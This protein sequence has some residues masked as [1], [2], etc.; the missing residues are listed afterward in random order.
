MQNQNTDP[1]KKLS[2][3]DFAAKI[4]TKYPQYADI[5]DGQL[6]DKITAKYPQYKE[7]IDFSVKKKEP[8]KTTATA[9]KPVSGLETTTQEPAKKDGSLATT[10]P[11]EIQQNE[12]LQTLLSEYD[13]AKQL[14]PED[15]Q[16]IAQTVEQESTMNFG[17]FDRMKQ[18]YSVASQANPF[19]PT[20]NYQDPNAKLRRKSA[21]AIA[22]DQEIDVNEVS[23]EQVNERVMQERTRELAQQKI[24]NKTEEFIESRSAETQQILNEHFNIKSEKLTNQSKRI[25]LEN[26]DAYKQVEVLDAQLESIKANHSKDQEYTEEYYANN[27]KLVAQRNALVDQIIKRNETLNETNEDLLSTQNEIDLFKRNYGKVYNM[28]SKFGNA[29]EEMSANLIEFGYRFST[30]PLLDNV[31]PEGTETSIAFDAMMKNIREGIAAEKE[32]LRRPRDLSNLQSAEDFTEWAMDLVAEQ[33]PNTIVMAS[34]GGSSSLAVLGASA[35][36]AKFNEMTEEEKNSLGAVNYTEAQKYLSA[37]GAFVFEAG[38]ERISLG[39]IRQAKR[40]FQTIGRDQLKESASKYLKR[41]VPE[42][43]QRVTEE[44]GTEAIAQFSQNLADKYYLGKDIDLMQGVGESFISGAFMSGVIYQAP[45]IFSGI[46]KSFSTKDNNQKIGENLAKIKQFNEQLNSELSPEVATKIAAKRDAL[47]LQNKNILDKS[48]ADIDELTY[49]QKQEILD[50]ENQKY[51]LRQETQRLNEESNLS[52]DVRKQLIE[53]NAAKIEKLDEQRQGI[54]LEREQNFLSVLPAEEQ[55]A[56]K[57]QAQRELMAEYEAQGVEEYEI[58]DQ[59]IT[60]RAVSLFE[61]QNTETNA[62]TQETT[63]EET[64]PEVL[65]AQDQKS[66]KIKV[67]HGTSGDFDRF[68]FNSESKGFGQQDLGKGVYFTES[69]ERADGYRKNA[70]INNNLPAESGRVMEVSITVNNPIDIASEEYGNLEETYSDKGELSQAIQDAGYDGIVYTVNGKKNYVVFNENQI[71]YSNES[72]PAQDPAI[73]EDVRPEPSQDNNTTENQDVQPTVESE[74]STTEAQTTTKRV[75]PKGVKGE[76]DVELDT[77]GEVTRVISVK[78]GREI[79]KFTERTNKRTGKKTMVRNANYSRIANEAIGQKTENQLREEAKAKTNVAID[80]YTPTNAYEAALDYFARGGNIS[81]A[82]ATK[83]TGYTQVEVKWAAGFNKDTDL[84]S[85]ERAAE[86]IVAESDLDL[87]VNEV[88]NE[89][90]AILQ[91]KQ[92]V[93]EVQN[94]IVALQEEANARQNEE[95]LYQYLGT[96]SEAQLTAYE[97]QVAEDTYLEQLTYEEQIEYYEGQYGTQDQ[98]IEAEIEG[99]RQTKPESESSPASIQERS[100]PQ[101]EEESGQSDDAFLKWLNKQSQDLDDFSKGTLGINL[102]VAVAQGAIKIVRTAYTAG[103]SASQAI[104]EALD[105]IKATDWYKGLSKK[106][107]REV[108][109]DLVKRAVVQENMSD[110]QTFDYIEKEFEEADK[111]LENKQPA[112]KK[113]QSLIRKFI[114]K[115]SDRQFI[116]KKLVDEVGAQQTKDAMINSHGASGKA[117]RIFD[118][119]FYQIYSDNL[120]YNQQGLQGYKYTWKPMSNADRAML[121]KIIQL[122]RFIAID[123]NRTEKGLPPVT[124]PGFIN[125]KM[126]QKY[127][128]HVKVKLGDEKFADIEKRAAIYFKTY[129]TLLEEMRKNGLIS[130]AVFES[131]DGLDYQP[132]LFLQHITDFEGNVSLGAAQ[133]EKSDTGGLSQDQIKAL[134]E[135]SSGVLVRNSEWLLATSIVARQRAMAMNTVNKVFMTKEFPAAKKRYQE[136]K[137]D[138]KNRKKWSREDERFYTYFTELNSK[139]KDNPI[140]KQKK[141]TEQEVID[142]MEP[143]YIYTRK[144]DK[145]PANFKKAYYYENGVRHEFFIEENLHDAWFDNIPGFLN[146]KAKEFLGYAMGASLLKGIATGNNPAFALV[147]TPRDYIFNVVFSDQ[148]SSIVPKAMYQVA[149]DTFKAIREIKRSN[150]SFGADGS[151]LDK[152]IYYGG[153]MAFLSTQGRLKQNTRLAKTIDK[154]LTPRVKNI[155]GTIFKAVTLRKLSEY[156]EVMFRMALFQRTIKNEL[157]ARGLKSMNA[158]KTQAEKDQIYM[159]AVA[160]ARSLLDFN[161]G[162]SYTKDAEAFIPYINTAVQ[163]TRVAADAFQKNPDK[164]FFKVMQSAVMLSGA[165]VLGSLALIKANKDDEEEKSAYE[166]WLE[167]ME[168]VSQYQRIQYFNIVDGT[169]DENGEYRVW[170]IAKNQQLAPVLN[171]ADNVYTQWVSDI[172]GVKRKDSN[173]NYAEAWTAIQNN[174]IPF[175]LEKPI[176]GNLTKTPVIKAGFTYGTGHDFYRDQPLTFD[177]N[178]DNPVMEGAQDKNVDDFYKEIGRE[179]RLSPARLKGAVE[180]LITTPRTNPFIGVLYAGADGIASEDKTLKDMAGKVGKDMLSSFDKRVISHTSD[181]NRQINRLRPVED[182]LK[183]IKTVNDYR[184]V[185]LE[186]L[187]KD[188]YNNK[189]SIPVFLEKLQEMKPTEKEAKKIE[190]K[191]KSLF[192]YKDVDRYVIGLAFESDREARA[193]KI[194]RYYGNVFDGSPENDRVFS[195]M[196]DMNVLDPETIVEYQKLVNKMNQ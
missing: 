161:Q 134:G 46:A 100:R 62:E 183:E 23:P 108:N 55:Q 111:A 64:Q 17:F 60:A 120:Y 36:G 107:Q 94:E 72:T 106:E 171:I 117:K 180:S 164:I 196:V 93:S 190:S 67:Y 129:H 176:T 130:D 49:E 43:I 179:Y 11:V 170:K 79:P 77:D 153:D 82:S 192:K 146:A 90:I 83:E 126:A 186:E 54:L 53:E 18:A 189:V 121:D 112:K 48:I 122:K 109:A 194:A 12:K 147:N 73:D 191:L 98:R 160:E 195:Q 19:L 91:A 143:E 125:G 104:K 110:E 80:N 92:S 4:K 181:F 175:D 139:I 168:G 38:S 40:V 188:L 14:T 45:G 97:S 9:P 154:L 57:D 151:L 135:G 8:Y 115:V 66:K 32:T 158:V 33:T 131:L 50:I 65:P 6:I 166:I 152:Y 156:S 132:R 81:L 15:E 172:A 52:D 87:D 78:D 71:E 59:E 163:G 138:I 144:Y 157:D 29:T 10:P 167:A 96:L 114:Q 155:A 69:K 173:V 22:R 136:L 105:Y 26:E 28:L 128:N 27:Q 95:E 185:D 124:H 1:G 116:S 119:A 187:T 85:I 75:N 76:F 178:Q 137:K 47:I 102:P 141:N 89:I 169:K 37:M 103:K 30:L 177:Q 145:T 101:G 61:N 21:E 70:N 24:D 162:G 74:P 35:G 99:N 25:L 118:K 159:R 51:K 39:Q 20:Y 88:R 184:E 2:P 34:T 56:L 150:G 3:A 133:S 142:G 127:L 63:T 149:K 13:A 5:E 86:G 68:D 174:I 58:S 113:R 41:Q 44:G 148:Y 16:E 42:Y 7:Q 165:S 84:P 123:K 140:I 193:L 31:L 182:D